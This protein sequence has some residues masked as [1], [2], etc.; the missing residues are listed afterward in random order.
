MPLLDT[1]AK[2]N[3]VKRKIGHD[4]VIVSAQPLIRD[5]ISGILNRSS[6]C[7]I[8]KIIFVQCF[9][10]EAVKKINLEFGKVFL[11]GSESSYAVFIE[12]EEITVCADTE[13]GLIGGCSCV[14][15]HTEGGQIEQGIIYSLPLLDFRGVK[16]FLPSRDNIPFFKEFVDFCIHF[17]YNKLMLEIGG[18]MEYKNHPEINSGWVEYCR[19]FKEYQGKTLDVQHRAKWAKNA[20]HMENGGGSYLTQD[21]VRELVRYCAE[22][23]IE[24]IPEVPCYSHSDYL[25]IN[26]HELAE[27]AQDDMPD[28]YCPSNPQSYKLLFDVLDEVIHVFAPEIINIGH[29][30]VY[31]IGLCDACKNKKAY[32][33]YAEDILKIHD[34]LAKRNVKTALWGDKLLNAIGRKGQTWGGSQRIIV[35]QAT[36]DF[37]EIVPSTYQ[38]IDLLPRDLQIF[39]WYW[40]IDPKFE[41][42]FTSRGFKTIY[43]NFS[44]PCMDNWHSRITKGID[45]ICISNWS[46]VDE[47]YMQRNGIFLNMAYTAMMLWNKDFDENNY[48]ENSVT[49][50]NEIYRYHKRN[51]KNYVEVKHRTTLLKEHNPYCDG[52]LIDKNDDY[53]GK[54]VILFEDGEKMDVPIYYGLNIGTSKAVWERKGDESTCGISCKG[55]QEEAA[56][57][58]SITVEDGETY[59]NYAIQIP[60]N[61]RVRSIGVSADSKYGNVIE[62]KSILVNYIN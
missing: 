59:Y 18:A 40:G 24:I 8:K 33:Q 10:E 20:I 16:T 35:N 36:G 19:Y 62:L 57:N 7:E 53:I 17:G 27:R 6:A 54:Y 51:Y 31:S 30:E 49:A 13:Q 21:E 37:L 14:M 2:L 34:Y 50:S 43:G 25:L 29:D 4:T 9:S 12:E 26:H 45:G 15:R 58:C 39:H 28:T 44:G 47:E 1:Y 32:E 3:G 42:E 60:D 55:Q 56:N 52:Y 22:R 61:K 23:H 41:D 11:P 5:W 46:M 38:A 48:I